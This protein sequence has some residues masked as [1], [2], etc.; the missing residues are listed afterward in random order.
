M[1]VFDRIVK[2]NPDTLLGKILTKN[3]EHMSRIS[4][5]IYFLPIIIIF[6]VNNSH[7]ELKDSVPK[8]YGLLIF[9]YF[10]SIFL[11]SKIRKEGNL[12]SEIMEIIICFPVYLSFLISFLI[13]RIFTNKKRYPDITEDKLH[14][15]QRS[16]KLKKVKR[17]IRRKKKLWVI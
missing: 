1:S 15:Y 2:R 11:I 9:W 10:M 3:S 12:L 17:K 4:F 8:I 5:M 6:F 16:V 14:L 13:F 7:N